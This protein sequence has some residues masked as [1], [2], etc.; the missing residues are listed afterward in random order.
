MPF[1]GDPSKVGEM[2]FRVFQ[3]AGSMA[4][5]GTRRGLAAA[6]RFC[7]VGREE[8]TSSESLFLV[9][10]VAARKSLLELLNTASG[11]HK[12]MLAG[13]EWVRS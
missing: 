11:V 6:W 1:I 4:G 12:G 5:N 8:R 10:E 7:R 9:L 2:A 3:D 13:E